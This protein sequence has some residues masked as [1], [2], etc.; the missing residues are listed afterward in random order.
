MKKRKKRYTKVVKN[1]QEE[2]LAVEYPEY[3]LKQE[4]EKIAEISMENNFE[5]EMSKQT[6]LT[7]H[8]RKIKKQPKNSN[9]WS[10]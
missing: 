3:L 10:Y 4:E 2:E 9:D 7:S 1:E 6:T 8:L 5:Q